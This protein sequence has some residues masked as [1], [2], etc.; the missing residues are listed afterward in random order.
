MSRY[1]DTSYSSTGDLPYRDA[2]SQRWDS[3]RFARE[4]DYRRPPIV[5]RPV[6]DDYRPPPRPA[7]P[8][9]E[10]ERYY[11]D[12]RYG[13]RG[14]RSERRY[15]EEDDYYRDDPRAPGGAMVSFR[16]ERA[17]P[18]VR[19]GQLIRRQSS[20]D[21]FD[22]RPAPRYENHYDYRPYPP[23]APRRTEAFYDEVK[24]QD[25][26]Y[27]GDEGFREFR[28]REWV[29]RRRR[30]TSDSRS[31][32]RERRSEFFQDIKEEKVE[33]PYP[34]KGKTR[35]PKRLVHTK[36]LYDL[37][38]PFYEED[39]KTILIEKALG[40]ENID[41]VFTLS[42]EYRGREATTTTT[43]RLIEAS[44]ES[45][46][47]SSPEVVREEKIVEKSE[48]KT[49]PI[50]EAARSVQEWD[51]LT[52]R[53]PSPKSHR[54]HRSRSR[55]R[56]RRGSSPV[57]ETFV[58][59]TVIEKEVSPRTSHTSVNDSETIIEK[60]KIISDEEIGESNSVHVGPLALVVDRRPSRTDRDIKDEIRRLEA[61][62]R[63]LRR[64]RRYDRDDEILRVERIREWSPSP[65]G[66]VIVERRGDEVIEVR[67][68]RRG[69][70]SLVR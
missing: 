58:Q 41:E 8:T 25:P 70:M 59:K 69:R 30:S 18:P 12:D 50:S 28:E 57:K 53:S 11:E 4:R 47:P 44:T 7:A 46:V 32:S 63:A 42:K 52:V 56:S 68:D 26:E 64:E 49:I 38:Y 35:M 24:I 19:P 17:E 20:L 27:Y 36:V 6:Y 60:T 65:K 67:K 2:P 10:R 54:S 43:T 61:E 39:D 1:R 13:P 9:Y 15:F 51:A 33:K 62:R 37:G 21:T 34:R 40:P 3:D 23:P 45:H 14:Q 55:R 31:R 48:V 5:E 66:E 16:P 29:R 22:R